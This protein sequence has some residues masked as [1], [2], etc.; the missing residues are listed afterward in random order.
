[1]IL[2]F[3]V[4]TLM[5][6]T[7]LAVLIVKSK[8]TAAN[9]TTR[10]INIFGKAGRRSRS[11]TVTQSQMKPFYQQKEP[12]PARQE[13]INKNGMAKIILFMVLLAFNV[14]FWTVALIQ[15]WKPVEEFN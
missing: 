8:D 6:H 4:L 7:H 13:A 1:M 11:A 12:L 2:S 9:S 5:I 14:T 10:I 15:Y 3:L